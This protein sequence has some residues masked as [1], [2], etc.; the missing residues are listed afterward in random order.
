MCTT[1]ID[2]LRHGEVQGGQKYRG[3]L[4][5]PLSDVGWKQLRETTRIQQDWQHI[6]TS[7]LK[8]CAEFAKELAQTNNLTLSTNSEFKEIS[9]GLWE[10]KTAEELLNTEPDHI[11]KF[12]A[13][14]INSTPPE[15][16]NLL[17][18]EQRVV[19]SWNDMVTE[20]KGKHIL[21]ISHAGVM[22]II[23]CHILAMPLKEIFKI[24]VALAKAS[25]I[26]ID[27]KYDTEWSRLI[28]HGSDFK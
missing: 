23:L 21:V 17:T 15:G 27:S 16:E 12:W 6:I 22:R 10:G 1:V 24:D 25:R 3:Q 4:D 19:N 8:R 11:K 28:F 5:E 14:P 26:Q 18:F 13:D 20:H 7:P 9:F 2:L